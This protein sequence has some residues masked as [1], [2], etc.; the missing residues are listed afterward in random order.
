MTAGA[1]EHEVGG[2]VGKRLGLHLVM[3]IA[4]S[5]TLGASWQNVGN[6]APFHGPSC[7]IVVHKVYPAKLAMARRLDP[8]NALCN[9][10]GVVTSAGSFSFFFLPHLISL[11]HLATDSLNS[12]EVAKL[13]FKGYEENRQK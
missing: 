3:I 9:L 5:G 8:D 4:R 2:I 1:E 10:I 12:D 13:E 11:K 7:A 6:L